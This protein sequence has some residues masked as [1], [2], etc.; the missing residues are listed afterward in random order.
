[1]LC[2]QHVI[3]FTCFIIDQGFVVTQSKV[4][5]SLGMHLEHSPLHNGSSS[6]KNC[7]SGVTMAIKEGNGFKLN[8]L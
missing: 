6:F 5:D 1:M 4:M 8:L 2:L 3:V 7:F